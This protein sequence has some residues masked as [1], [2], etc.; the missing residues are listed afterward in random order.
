MK[1]ENKE[2]NEE[3]LNQVSGGCPMC[4]AKAEQQ[5][6]SKG[7]KSVYNPGVKTNTPVATW[8]HTM[9]AGKD[10]IPC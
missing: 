8:D 7:S 10:G 1:D 4:G 3:E 5:D 9:K 2:L 6:T